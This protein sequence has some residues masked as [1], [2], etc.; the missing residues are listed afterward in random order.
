MKDA[1]PAKEG[2]WRTQ[3]EGGKLQAKDQGEKRSKEQFLLT[4]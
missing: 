2:S 3:R 4:P 1:H